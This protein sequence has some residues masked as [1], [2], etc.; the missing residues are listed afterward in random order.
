MPNTMSQRPTGQI[1]LFL[2]PVEGCDMRF[3]S[4]HG[5]TQ[6][7][8]AKHPNFGINEPKSRSQA[9]DMD[10]GHRP[11]D[12]SP[13]SHTSQLDLEADEHMTIDSDPPPT[14]IVFDDFLQLPTVTYSPS[15]FPSP[16]PFDNMI[17]FS[18][19]Q[20]SPADTADESATCAFTNY[21]L[22]LNGKFIHSIST[23]L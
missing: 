11:I 23:A 12:S 15:P 9:D 7:I 20:S 21:H 2:C 10:R 3:K 14:G 22:I 5:Q 4:T 8:C 6:H 1:T 16:P 19:S 17:P 13:S 18:T